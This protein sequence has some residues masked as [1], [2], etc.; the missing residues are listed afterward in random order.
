MKL[1]VLSNHFS[2]DIFQGHDTVN[3]IFIPGL[4][5]DRVNFLFRIIFKAPGT[6]M[7]PS[8]LV[9]LDIMTSRTF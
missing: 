2:G 1:S 6:F 4:H 7:I 9:K 3:V 5:Q 8:T